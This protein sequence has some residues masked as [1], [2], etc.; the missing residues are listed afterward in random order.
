M[1]S[2]PGSL[3]I[4]RTTVPPD[5]YAFVAHSAPINSLVSLLSL[6]CAEILDDR[7]GR[8]E[9]LC[10]DLSE[11]FS[12]FWYLFVTIVEFHFEQK[13]LLP[14]LGCVVDNADNIASLRPPLPTFQY[15]LLQQK[16]MLLNCCVEE[17]RNN[18]EEGGEK[19]SEE[20]SDDSPLF[21][22]DSEDEEESFVHHP[23][24]KGILNWSG[25]F[26]GGS[27]VPCWLPITRDKAILTVVDGAKNDP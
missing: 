15:N 6:R 14:H 4:P 23:H 12:L 3:H 17:L 20:D 27:D 18:N 19:D 21:F 8:R 5:A 26:L 22:S 11:T 25:W 10:V 7:G 13:R 16:L 9:R 24:G 1:P 2:S